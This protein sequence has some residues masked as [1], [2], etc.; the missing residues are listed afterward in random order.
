MMGGEWPDGSQPILD[1]AFASVSDRTVAYLTTAL[2]P[3]DWPIDQKPPPKA[4]LVGW[5]IDLEGGYFAYQWET[6]ETHLTETGEQ[7]VE[8]G[9]LSLYPPDFE[10][11]F[12]FGTGPAQASW[13]N[14]DVLE[15][16]KARASWVWSILIRGFWTQLA[17]EEFSLFARPSSPLSDIARVPGDVWRNFKP[18]GVDW[19]RG[20]AVCPHTGER[21]F[22]L[23]VLVFSVASA[24]TARQRSPTSADF[25]ALAEFGESRAAA[26]APATIPEMETWARNRGLSREFVREFRKNQPPDQKL[27]RGE[28]RRRPNARE[29]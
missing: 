1:A 21:L 24:P 22:S 25:A 10:F 20:I 19:H 5:W 27:R 28:R 9:L 3:D 26:G 23:H 4:H 29:N 7:P 16:V 11:S 13:F 6:L 12:G 17:D 14:P 15:R 2:S 8:S 18:E